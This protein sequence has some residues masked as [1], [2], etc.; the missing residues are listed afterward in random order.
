MS[1]SGQR[2]PSRQRREPRDGAPDARR[3]GHQGGSGRQR[4][5]GSGGQTRIVQPARRVAYDVLRAVS[6]SDAYANLL[7]PTAI[8]D[9][10]LTP[11]DAALATEL[12][13]GTLRRRGM[14]DAIIV[15]AAERGIDGIDPAVL[16][17][18]R[19][20]VHQL[21]ATRVAPHAAVNESV[22]L[23]ATVAGRGAAS[24]TNAVLRRVARDTPEQW[25]EK[26][27]QTARSDD[28][29]LALRSAHP[30]WVIRALRRALAAEGRVDELEELLEAD[31]ASPEVTLVALPGLAE[32]ADPRRP[33]AATAF[34]SP[35]G[36]PRRSVAASG[37]AV[38]VQDEGSQLVALALADAAPVRA[39][40]RWLDLCAGPGGK[41][42]LLA[43]VALQRGA[44][45]EANEIVPTRARLVRNAL[46]AV[47]GDV[48]VHEQ[49]GRDF[50]GTHAGQFDRILVDAPCTGLGALR[51]RPEARWRK[52]PA[53]VAELVPLQEGL[54]SAALD[55]LAPGGIVA[56]A[57]CSPHLAETVGVVQE[58]LRSRSDIEELDARAV[59]RN[60]AQSPID[61]ADE[62]R[63][64]GGSVQLW[65]HRHGTDAMFL[66]LLRRTAI[67]STAERED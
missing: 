12:T 9:A 63:A 24:F 39:G 40:E 51:R 22:N 49:D 10:G 32:P 60:L 23:V 62:G 13:Y 58:V 41:T 36:D 46:R 64:D 53:D 5:S 50:G 56:Y 38:R 37:G 18:L 2:R 16:D 8:A 3:A 59:V 66:T 1:D 20:A 26:I 31:N 55:A 11:Q 17:A 54:L 43:A 35:G 19:L 44:L 57:T 7:L 65:P 4:G 6:D 14:Y 45:L 47:P 42:A 25:Q 33:F 15:S 27:E 30:V 61:L 48:P 21:L 28:E 34:A 52:S 29:R 67:A